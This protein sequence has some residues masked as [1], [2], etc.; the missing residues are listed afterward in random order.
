LRLCS[1]NIQLG[2]RIEQVREDIRTR[3]EFRDLDV[4]ALQEAS[5]QEGVEDAAAIARELGPE[6]AHYQVTAQQ[7]K[8]RSQANALVWNGDRLSAVACGQLDLPSPRDPAGLSPTERWLL[9][10]VR[11]QRRGAV[12]LD[13][14]LPSG[15]AIRLYSVHA[16]VLGFAHRRRQ[17]STVIGHN[18]TRRQVALAVI[19]G[20]LNT[21]GV[22]S[23]PSWK[24]LH[25]GI[26]DAGFLDVTGEV[27]W[28]HEVA[29]L[30]LRQ[31]LDFI[32]ATARQDLGYRAWTLPTQASDHLP[33][34]VELNWR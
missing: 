15:E 26:R 24:A 12:F 3:A 5:I 16:D 14:K 6:Y 20:D 27:R 13:A 29:R 30:R 18:D 31:K 33:Q 7:M 22:A 19:A 23:I 8:G 32:F 28:T 4:L 10:G 2:G 1:W 34:F 11:D 21:F 25:R 17:L 9:R